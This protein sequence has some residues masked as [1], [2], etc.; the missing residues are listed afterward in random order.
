MAGGKLPNLRRLVSH[1]LSSNAHAPG[2][3]ILIACI[4]D[5]AV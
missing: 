4:I 2:W 5:Y 1:L 3:E